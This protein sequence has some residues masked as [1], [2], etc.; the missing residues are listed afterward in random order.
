MFGCEIG[1]DMGP[2]NRTPY[3]RGG[4]LAVEGLKQRQYSIQPARGPYEVW[5]WN[6]KHFRAISFFT[7]ATLTSADPK[8]QNVA[9]CH[10]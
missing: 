6:S 1:R 8:K 4:S 7:G 9:Q 2:P 10:K 5:C 3:R